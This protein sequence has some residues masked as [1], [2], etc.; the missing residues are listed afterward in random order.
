[1]DR[2]ALW[3]Q[4]MGSQRVGRDWVTED[5]SPVGKSIT[6]RGDSLAMNFCLEYHG[7]S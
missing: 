7:A 5:T 6:C 2:G 1:M 3:L 4:S